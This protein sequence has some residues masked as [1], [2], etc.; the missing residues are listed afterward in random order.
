MVHAKGRVMTSKLSTTEEIIAEIR[1]GKMVIL[2][3]DE[4]RENEGDI[5]VAAEAATPEAINFM[6]RFGRGLICLCLPE[7][8][9][10]ALDLEPMVCD[11]GTRHG[12]AFTASINAAN[13]TEAPISAR[14][15]AH[16]VAVAINE[17]TGPCDI[18]TPGHIFPLISRPGGVLVRTGHTEAAV[19]LARL[20]GLKPAGVICEV[21]NGDGT[22]ARLNDLERFAKE[23]QLKL[24]TIRDLVLYRRR[25]DRLLDRANSRN[26]ETNSFGTWTAVIYRNRIDGSEVMAL[27]KGWID[28][29]RPTLVRMHIP[30]ALYDLFDAKGPRRGLIA[31]S[32]EQIANE[33]R[34]VIVLVSQ[35]SLR[36]VAAFFAISEGR[37]PTHN[38]VLRDYE[39]G[40]EV[41]ADL[42]VH[43]M[44][45]LTNSNVDPIGLDGYGLKIVGE[46]A[47]AMAS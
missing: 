30:D 41:L 37:P 36:S 44:I 47:I 19:D 4:G 24:G 27:V 45:L 11:N 16:T 6:A 28:P 14:S 20:A 5:I 40:A 32:M 13:L 22:M 10:R 42:G 12:T 18:V 31:A 33:G 7:D 29:T 17:E 8:R 39:I 34:G 3:D 21:M 15:R 25:H 38:E 9:I 26:I 1:R 46:R 23:H 2:V 35:D 43:D